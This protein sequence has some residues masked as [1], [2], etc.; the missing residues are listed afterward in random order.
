MTKKLGE[1]DF[2]CAQHNDETKRNEKKR[3]K[4]SSYTVGERENFNY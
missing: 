1:K 3:K 2:Q 4:V